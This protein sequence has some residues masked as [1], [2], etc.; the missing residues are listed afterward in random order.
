VVS[1]LS[2]MSKW[3][4]PWKTNR[5]KNDKKS[6]PT[7]NTT[8]TAIISIPL[9]KQVPT[10]ACKLFQLARN[11]NNQDQEVQQQCAS[12]PEEAFCIT[13]HSLRTALHLVCLDHTLSYVAIRCLLQANP[14]ALLVVDKYGYTPLHLICSTTTH[15]RNNDTDE[16]DLLIPLF[17]NA[18]L[19]LA[20]TQGIL[21]QL[22]PTTSSSTVQVKVIP[23]PLAL[24][25]KR[26][27]PLTSIRCVVETRR[28][29]SAVNS[30]ALSWIAPLT[31]GEPYSY[32]SKDRGTTIPS[33]T[34]A[35][36]ESPLMLLCQSPHVM[37]VLES[38]R[39]RLPL[40]LDP[41]DTT[42]SSSWNKE[43]RFATMARLDHLHPNPIPPRQEPPF[44]HLSGPLL[45]SVPPQ[46]FYAWSAC[47]ELVLPHC[48]PLQ[49]QPQKEKLEPIS[50]SITT[51]T[52][53]PK[54][55]NK[56]EDGVC[57]HI[58]WGVVHAVASLSI[59]ELLQLDLLQW[60][61]AVFPEQ[62]QQRDAAGKIPLHHVLQQPK[63][64]SVPENTDKILRLV[65]LLLQ[66]EPLSARVPLVFLPTVQQV[67]P[68]PLLAH[69][70]DNDTND[71]SRLPME[72]TMT[73]PITRSVSVS[74][75]PLWY[76]LQV[77]HSWPV[78]DALVQAYP[79]ALLLLPEDVHD[80]NNS[81]DNNNNNSN[82]NNNDHD[83]NDNNNIHNN[84]LL[85]PY[86]LAAV[87]EYSLDVI[88]RLLIACPQ[89]LTF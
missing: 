6:S 2:I 66:H 54:N 10:S 5:K 1:S 28:H 43:L 8:A 84:T 82:D 32:S 36:A 88:Y 14:H 85:F 44:K 87:Q 75:T 73:M 3:L 61:L 47:I 63:H 81:N 67:V 59:C 11:P 31:G 64:W 12:H 19:E 46:I 53:I 48:P 21:F 60:C 23:S 26:G 58:E 17:L 45:S 30:K 27:A 55:T 35:M 42:T 25:A 16:E 70:N 62:A 56:E 18:I 68:P 9:Y 51:S 24:A 89:V 7:T 15:C 65:Q 71:S 22:P 29:Y 34:T 13:N 74:V 78:I 80:N 69:D 4:F 33:N 83:V 52:T 76:A 37:N 40:L 50:S 20:E 39:L 38:Q 72:P 86:Q 41:T 57:D 77:Q 49:P 79:N